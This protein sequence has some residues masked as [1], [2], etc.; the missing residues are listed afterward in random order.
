VTYPFKSL[1]GAVTVDRQRS[2]QRLFDYSNEGV[3]HYGLYADWAEEVR[4]LGGQQIASDLLRG[5]EAYLQMWERAVGVPSTRCVGRRGR[6]RPRRLGAIGLGMTSR[7]LLQSAGQPLRR[8]RAWTYCVDG[9]NRAATTAVLTPEGMV[10]LIASSAPGHR[11]R[12]IRPGVK[13]AKLRGGAKRIGGGVWISRLGKTRIAYLVK[14]KRV[15]TVAIAGPEARGRKA[16]REYLSLVPRAAM[17]ARPAFAAR[18]AADP[19]TAQN[20]TP[21]V[22]RHD[23]AKNGWYCNLGL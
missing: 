22:R 19:V 3:A 20:A 4:K 1:D 18:R 5:P 15:R 7:A 9:N 16:L 14:G 11:A 12:G 23:P 6:F 8:T 21:L 10:A 13:F 17:K 2:G